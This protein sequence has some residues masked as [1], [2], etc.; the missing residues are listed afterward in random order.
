MEVGFPESDFDGKLFVAGHSNS[1]RDSRGLKRGTR[2]IKESLMVGGADFGEDGGIG[3]G[4]GRFLGGKKTGEDLR[5]RCQWRRQEA[6]RE[7]RGWWSAK[8]NC[9]ARECRSRRHA[10]NEPVKSSLRKIPENPRRH[11]R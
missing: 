10:R 8:R 2:S 3:G 5:R 1:T 6:P 11:F 7:K 4:Y 9:V